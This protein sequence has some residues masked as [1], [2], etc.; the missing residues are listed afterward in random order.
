MEDE[1]EIAT[2]VTGKECAP[3]VEKEEKTLV[4]ENCLD[5]DGLSCFPSEDGVPGIRRTVLSPSGAELLVFRLRCGKK[6]L[7][8]DFVLV[9]LGLGGK[10]ALTEPGLHK[11]YDLADGNEFSKV[12]SGICKEVRF[13][14]RE[15]GAEEISSL[16]FALWSDDCKAI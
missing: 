8:D 4:K 2:G 1:S 13:G 9:E 6:L 14:R 16:M 10:P 7:M 5:V 11:V 15:L 12:L 3:L